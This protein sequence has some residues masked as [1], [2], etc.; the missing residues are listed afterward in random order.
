MLMV[1]RAGSLEARTRVKF[2]LEREQQIATA[3][4]Q[5]YAVPIIEATQQ[6]DKEQKIDRW[7]DSP[8]GRIALQI[9]YREVGEDMLF[10][11]YDKWFGWNDERNKLGRDMQGD[12]EQY[13]VLL[14]DRKTVVMVPTA[15]AKE[16]VINL[17]EQAKKGWTAE[18]VQ[19][20]KTLKTRF[21]GIK[22]ELKVQHDPNDARIKMIAYIPALYFVARA[23]AKVY[24]VNLPEW[25]H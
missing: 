5:Q 14:S 20:T 23:Q 10:E 21:N 4:K 12:A 11:V 7:I 18:S 25:N 15:L 22:M 2:G 8:H 17:V 1:P 16:T 24:N 3:L 6:E 19:G 9:K 13:A